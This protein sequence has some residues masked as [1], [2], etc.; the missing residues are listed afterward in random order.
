MPRILTRRAISFALSLSTFALACG[1]DAASV[2]ETTGSETTESPSTSVDTTQTTTT[3]DPDSS[4]SPS[5]TVDPDTSTSVTDPTTGTESS[6]TDADSSSSSEGGTDTDGPIDPGELVECDNVIPAAPEGSVCGVT[7]GAGAILIRGTVLAGHRVYENGTVLVQGGQDN[8]RILCTGCDCADAPEAAGA[9]VLDCAQGV[10]SPGL[11][12]PHD[13]ITFTLSQPQGHGTERYDHRHE[14]RLGQGGH[15]P[16][17]TFPGS[18]SSLEG[19]LYGEVRMLLGGATSVTGSI[20]SN[21]ARGLLRNLDAADMTEGLNGVDV[22]YRTFPLGD[23]SGPTVL[24]DCDYPSI[25]GTFNLEDDV[26]LPHVA[27]GV[28]ERANNEFQCMSGA[29]GGEELIAGHTSLIHGIGMLAEDVNTMA[30]ANAELV[31]SPRS[32]IDLY[33]I[34]ADIPTYRN[35]GVGV[36]LGTDWTAS[37]SMNMLRELRCADYIDTNHYGDIIPDRD[38]WL[39]ATYWAALSQGADDQIGLLRP[40]HIADIAIFDGSQH[41]HHRAVIEAGVQDVALVMRGGQALYG[42]ASVIEGL[43]DPALVGQCESIAE[44]DDCGSP[45][46]VCLQLDTGISITALQAAVDPQSYDLFFCGDPDNEPTCNPSREMEFPA[47]EGVEDADG[48]GVPDDDD[49]CPSVFNPVRPLDQA[50]QADDDQDGIGDSCDLC[51]LQDGQNCTLPDLYDRD[52]DDIIDFDDNCPD[53][54]NPAQTDTDEDWIGDDCDV[55]PMIPNPGGGACPSS[56]YEIKDGTVPEG[57]SVVLDDVLVTA[58][59]ATGYFVQV[60]PDDAAYVGP[61]FSGVFVFTNG[62]FVPAAGDRVDVT[63]DVA[64]FFGQ[65][66]IVA[67]TDAVVQSSDNPDVPATPT[68]I[69]AIIEG[70]VDQAA[71]EGVVVEVPNIVVADT[72]PAGGPGDNMPVGEF[73]ATGGLRVNDFFYLLTPPPQMGQVFP[74]LR[75]VSRWANDYTKLEP[76][77]PQDVPGSLIGFGPALVYLLVGS[78]DVVPTPTLEVTISAPAVADTP[79]DLAYGDPGIVSGPAQ[80]IVATG[81]TTALVPLDGLATGDGDV[82][83]SY[84]GTDIDVVVR[85]YDDATPRVPTLSPDSLLIA[86]DTSGELTVT[87]NLPAPAGGQMVAMSANPGTF[88]MVAPVVVVTAGELSATFDVTA[89]AVGDEVIT[90]DIGGA[91]DSVDVSVADIP[92]FDDLRIV[93][94]YYDHTGAGDDQFEWVK[95]Y[96]GTAST[97][98]LADY[99]IGWG[100]TDYTYGTLQ[101]VGTL[102]SGECHLVGGPNGNAA[103]GFPG[104]VVFDQSIDFNPD[105][106]N[107]GD[108]ADGVALFD[109]P[110][111]MITANTVPVHAVLYGPVN[112][113]GLIDESGAAGLPDVADVPAE[114]SVQMAEDGTWAANP[115]PAPL[116]CLPLP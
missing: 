102:A 33:G 24:G 55:C 66:Q 38:L 60:H 104:A 94:V 42:D 28:N 13:H 109:L 88:V 103:S 107:S 63:G 1:D 81:E 53:L 105:I 8:G 70:G 64:D 50:I 99:A 72:T 78:D 30:T 89:I 79:V 9:T 14:W 91:T 37:G 31:W 113:N 35:L 57:S 84:G 98:D 44:L 34:T 106:Q 52:G 115:D 21:D 87:L 11:I 93:E 7:P 114:T 108:A 69:D 92:T 5:T 74:Y 3:I 10:I 83:A 26:Y 97:V 58:A 67:T 77:G 90:A 100:G 76:R 85:V 95:L 101:L 61:E 32:N 6:S 46:R 4:T 22:N 17:D 56:I 73:E 62:A 15:D 71:L 45:K 82:T 49:L 111:N 40:G 41:A 65:I 59:A 43:V 20:S 12:N 19:I 86:A 16:I 47:R 80:V 48:D 68:T 51:P 29:P 39:M 27:E 112:T 75:G 116:A 25:D 36:A 23:S 2:D 18:D 54:V 110:A 96:N